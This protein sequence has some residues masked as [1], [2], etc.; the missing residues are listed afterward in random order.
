MSI[1]ER[2][3]RRERREDRMIVALFA[4]SAAYLAC[5]V[6]PAVILIVGEKAEEV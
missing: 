3:E 6:P 5:I 4:I 1:R 2:E